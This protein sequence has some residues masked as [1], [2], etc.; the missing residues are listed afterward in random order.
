MSRAKKIRAIVL[1]SGGLDS[2]L[3]VK[4]LQEQKIYVEGIFFASPFWNSEKAEITAKK[5]KIKLNIIEL[6]NDYL[7][8]IKNPCFGRGKKIN[9]C[10]DC[11]IF[12]LKKAKEFIEKKNF[13]FIAT[14]EVLGQRPMTQ[15]KFSLNLIEKKSGLF[16]KILRPLSA[17]V[18]EQTE[19]EKQGKISRESFFN[20]QGRSRR[21]QMQM[22]KERKILKYPN[23]AGGCLLT[24][25][26]FSK[27]AEE[28]FEK[29][30]RCKICDME[31]LKL[32]R[33][34]WIDKTKIVVGRNE[35]ENKKLEKIAEKKDILMELKKI[36]GPLVLIRGKINKKILQKAK[37]LII[38]YANKEDEL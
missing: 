2:M 23:P 33:H 5:F 19:I 3:A 37:D 12:M 14:G 11:R 26:E 28:L 16:G 27:R 10:I 17:K 35:E 13:D 1:F 7:H 21:R 38:R 6:E 4:I 22:A 15:N 32:G 31:L 29:F 20:I 24:D 34:F 30:P 25:S 9:P 8:I 36:P 18:L